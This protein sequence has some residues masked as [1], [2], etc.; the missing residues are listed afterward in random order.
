M[1][2]QK[3]QWKL[4]IQSFAAWAGMIGPV[5][6]VGVFTIEGF[7]RPAYNPFS[8]YVSELSIGS[9]GGFKS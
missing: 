4:D 3:G 2:I 8:M 5:L 7:L 6:F 9:R 1:A